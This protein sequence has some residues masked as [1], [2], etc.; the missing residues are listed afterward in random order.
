MKIQALVV[1][2]SFLI[3]GCGGGKDVDA[4]QSAADQGDYESATVVKQTDQEGPINR[5]QNL[6]PPE[7]PISISRG[8]VVSYEHTELIISFEAGGADRAF[9][10]FEGYSC[11]G[12]I[13]KDKPDFL[14]DVSNKGA[15]FTISAK[16]LVEGEAVTIILKSPDEEIA[17]YDR[18][19]ERENPRVEIMSGAVGRFEVFV[20]MME[21]QTGNR[22]QSEPGPVHVLVSSTRHF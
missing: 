12:M 2:L 7:T 21:R 13:R 1:S 19:Y 5:D 9:T 4:M 16:P 3:A 15:A 22:S 17:C 10:A 11:S 18:I 20:G 8:S 14:L 6:P